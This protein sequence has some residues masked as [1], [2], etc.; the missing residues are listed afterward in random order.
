MDIFIPTGCAYLYL[1]I[2]GAFQKFL[3]EGDLSEFENQHK[4]R[5]NH[6]LVKL[7]NLAHITEEIN[8]V[9][10]RNICSTWSISLM[11]LGYVYCF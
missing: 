7:V 10:S 6:R 2:L 3:L 8:Y 4:G 11:W 1:L 9:G 5:Y